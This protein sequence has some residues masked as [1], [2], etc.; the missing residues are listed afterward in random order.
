MLVLRS[1]IFLSVMNSFPMYQSIKF[2]PMPIIMFSYYIAY[3]INLVTK[4]FLL[5][6]S[7]FFS[8]RMEHQGF[9]ST[10]N[11]IILEVPVWFNKL[12]RKRFCRKGLASLFESDINFYNANLFNLFE[13]F[14]EQLK[15]NL[16]L[17]F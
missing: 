12:V 16:S 1:V 5:L 14:Y 10:L 2:S 17:I 8:N 6:L 4:C 3:R 15:L 13:R 7:S 9:A 11:S